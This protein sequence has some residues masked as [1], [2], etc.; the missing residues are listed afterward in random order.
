MC[1]EKSLKMCFSF[2]VSSL[3]TGNICLVS[4]SFLLTVSQAYK[5]ELFWIW[6]FPAVCCNLLLTVQFRGLAALV[7]W[8]FLPSAAGFLLAGGSG[9]GW[10][11]S[12]LVLQQRKLLSKQDTLRPS[13]AP[14]L[15]QRVTPA[16]ISPSTFPQI[17]S[18][19]VCERAA[20]PRPKVCTEAQVPGQC[21]PTSL[22]F[23][24]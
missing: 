9:V 4:N 20:A 23:T 8:V 22:F 5:L 12:S 3:Q 17:P 16:F 10:T 6:R 2:L 18:S 13:D 14:W 21:Y 24:V 19:E 11:C 7:Q 15:I 1:C